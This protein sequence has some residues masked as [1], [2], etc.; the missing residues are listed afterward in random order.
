MLD[1]AWPA[2]SE[3]GF[4]KCFDQFRSIAW[5]VCVNVFVACPTNEE[6]RNMTESSMRYPGWRVVVACFVMTFFGFGFGFY[7]L[8]VYLAALTIREGTDSLRISVSTVSTAVTVYFLAAAAIMVYISDLIARLGPR[9]FAAIGAVM[10]GVS[11]LLIARIRSTFDLFAAYLAMAPAFAMLTNAAVA[12]IV[13]LWFTQKRGLA[14]SIALTGGGVGGLVIVPTLVLLSSKLSFATGL[15]VG[16]A[17]TIPVLLLVISLC[18]RPPTAEEAKTAGLKEGTKSQTLTRRQALA[19]AH[20][21]TIAAPLMLAIMVQ[22]GFVVHQIAFLFPVLGREGAGLAVF[23]TALMAA[24]GRVVVGFFI[25]SLDQR[26]VGALLLAAQVSALFAMTKFPSPHVAFLASG[27]FGFAV[28]VMITLPALIIQRECP[29]AAFGMLSGLTLAIIQTGNAFGPLLLGCL[30]DATGDYAVPIA[31]C[32]AIEIT[33]IAIILM[34]ISPPKY[35]QQT[36][37]PQ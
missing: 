18:I 15:D 35:A 16:T 33:A 9:L 13:G 32:M 14:M 12:N 36:S 21:W 26:I 5:S 8:S 2:P 17:L 28:G 23:L 6:V 31:A 1:F 19:T 4:Q 27:V 11:L 25:D 30:R 24:T 34:R 22:V 3:V 7:G 10:M 20:Y 29:P 37:G